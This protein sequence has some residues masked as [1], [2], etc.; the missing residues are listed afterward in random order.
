[1]RIGM[2]ELLCLHGKAVKFGAG[3]ATSMVRTK[4]FTSSRGRKEV[5]PGPGTVPRDPNPIEG[6]RVSEDI[7]GTDPS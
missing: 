7:P 3:V 1:M 4:N 6:S 2:N 5:G